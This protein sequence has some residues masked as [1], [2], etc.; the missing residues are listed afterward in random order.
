M[1]VG[2][3]ERPGALIPAA[4]RTRTAPSNPAWWNVDDADAPDIRC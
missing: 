4:S 1:G 3:D 2:A